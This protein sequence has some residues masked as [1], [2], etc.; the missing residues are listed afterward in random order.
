MKIIIGVFDRQL[1][2]KLAIVFSEKKILPIEA[3]SIEEIPA[4]LSRHEGAILL[5][6]ELS[7]DFHRSIKEKNP[8][9]ET[10]LLYHSSL[11][12]E[13][14]SQLRFCGLRGLVPYS[15]N[16]H[17]AVE[18]LMRYLS[19]LAGKIKTEE[20][21]CLPIDKNQSDAA[22]YLPPSKIWLYGHLEGFNGSKVAVKFSPEDLPHIEACAKHKILLYMQGLKIKAEAEILQVRNGVS[23]FRYC[24][25]S[26]EDREKLIYYINY[27]R[28][29]EVSVS[30]T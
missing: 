2:C 11:S 1:S 19:M 9:T 6:E 24:Q 7:P 3:E 12:V 14:I 30:S 13:E 10:F 20:K 16:V 21:A 22:I 28:N 4:L 17:S 18:I 27:C 8:N 23:V 5:T 29:I 25:M 26:T 15:D